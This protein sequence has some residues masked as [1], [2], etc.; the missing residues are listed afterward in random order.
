MCFRSSLLL[1]QQ[2]SLQGVLALRD[3]LV[4]GSTGVG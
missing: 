1:G 4:C 2:S 3:V